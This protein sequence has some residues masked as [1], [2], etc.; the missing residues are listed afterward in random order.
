MTSEGDE[1]KHLNVSDES[2]YSSEGDCV[3]LYGTICYLLVRHNT[4]KLHN[5]PQPFL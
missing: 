2:R 1:G 5:R 3:N 4:D